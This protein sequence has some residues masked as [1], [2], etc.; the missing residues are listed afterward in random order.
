MKF[1]FLFILLFSSME[2][3]SQ[4]VYIPDANFK[5]HLLAIPALNINADTAIQVSE[6]NNYAIGIN[7]FAQNISSLTGIEA[8][9]NIPFLFCEA[10]QITDLDLSNNT[11]LTNIRCNNNQLVSLNIGTNTN[12]LYLQCQFN[13]LPE[14][15]ISGVP[16][17]LELNA[18]YNLLDSIDLS[19]NPD[20]TLLNLEHNEISRIDL[21]NNTSLETFE[22]IE[23]KLQSLDLSMIP[24]IEYINVS[25]QFDPISSL[26]TLT[27]FSIRNGNNTI[28][29]YFDAMGNNNLECIEVDDAVY[30]ETNWTNI[31]N[32]TEF[33]ENCH[34]LIIDEIGD[35]YSIYPTLSTGKISFETETEL[36]SKINIYDFSGKLAENF[37]FPSSNFKTLEL[38][39]LSNGMYFYSVDDGKAVGKFM[40]EK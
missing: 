30:S 29:T 9:I 12:L 40:I 4:N 24:T 13:Q 32:N 14:L 15:I 25:I 21:S 1:K 16:N 27:E 20:L 33:S 35:H 3:Y 36:F 7:C 2:I 28:I 5:S 26:K 17:L 22:I 18:R 10:N 19:N 11:F 8:F 38:S 6:A 39:N 37:S 34:P 23:N 31:H